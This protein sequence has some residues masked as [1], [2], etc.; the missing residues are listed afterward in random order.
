[1]IVVGRPNSALGAAIGSPR[2]MTKPD[3]QFLPIVIDFRALHA[4]IRIILVTGGSKAAS[5]PTLEVP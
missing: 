2:Q 5:Q 4:Y 1:M 3:R